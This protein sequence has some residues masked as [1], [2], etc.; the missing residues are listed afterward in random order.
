MS[1]QDATLVVLNG[2]ELVGD[3]GQDVEKLGVRADGPRADARGP[4]HGGQRITFALNA[5]KRRRWEREERLGQ[6]ELTLRTQQA[7]RDVSTLGRCSYTFT[8][9]WTLNNRAWRPLLRYWS[10]RNLPTWRGVG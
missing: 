9:Y 4:G 10:V 5:G 2:L 1:A 8:W 7:G 3:P 6:G